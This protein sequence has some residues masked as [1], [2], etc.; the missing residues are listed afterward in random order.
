MYH[1]F[2]WYFYFSADKRQKAPSLDSGFR[3]VTALSRGRRAAGA[4]A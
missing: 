3:S 1:Y 4:L 2:V